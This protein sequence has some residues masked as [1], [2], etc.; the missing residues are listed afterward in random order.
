MQEL[1]DVLVNTGNN[2]DVKNR[3][4]FKGVANP[5]TGQLDFSC[6]IVPVTPQD[7]VLKIDP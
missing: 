6:T 1:K 5:S 4:V 7:Q 3:I 2:P